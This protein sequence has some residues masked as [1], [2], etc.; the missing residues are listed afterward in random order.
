MGVAGPAE[1]L[2]V[3]YRCLEL[4]N[5][6]QSASVI[7]DQLKIS[8]N[9]VLGRI[10]RYKI[11]NPSLDLGRAPNAQPTDKNRR[12]AERQRAYRARDKADGIARRPRAHVPIPVV[13][14]SLP[15]VLQSPEPPLPFITLLNGILW[16][17]D[18]GCCWINSPT[19]HLPVL[20]C[21]APVIESS[22]CAS[23][24]AFHARLMRS[25]R[26]D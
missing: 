25:R 1:N 10:H 26:T 4:W 9:A 8:R 16:H 19:G 12:H 2:H 6:G 21:N 7:A 20:W 11:R 22:G 15:K 24:C 18:N 13:F 23:W 5:L 17:A 14:S 3:T